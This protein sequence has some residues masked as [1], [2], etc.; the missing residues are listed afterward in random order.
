MIIKL[1]AEN[2]AIL[3]TSPVTSF[4]SVWTGVCMRQEKVSASRGGS[5]GGGGF[6]GSEPPR[7]LESTVQIY[8][9]TDKENDL[10]PCLA[11]FPLIFLSK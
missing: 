3:T 6:G 4:V 1:D 5:K 7:R 11:T 2:K 10:E 9:K 8:R